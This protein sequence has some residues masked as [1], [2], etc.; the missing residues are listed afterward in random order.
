MASKEAEFNERVKEPPFAVREYAAHI[1]AQTIVKTDFGKA[2]RQAFGRLFKY[3]SGH[4]RS[5][6]S[7]SGA[8]DQGQGQGQKIA[9]TSPVIQNK[10]NEK[11]AMTSPVH[12]RQ[13]N[14]QWQVSF[15]MPAGSR[16]AELPTPQDAS[17][18]LAAV[19][20]QCM[21]VIRYSGSWSEARFQAHK[22]RLEH[23]I[24]AKGYQAI[25]AAS[26]ARYNPPFTL[27]FLRRNEILI[28]ISLP[29]EDS[30]DR[31]PS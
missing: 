14:E 22:Q 25:G 11:I 28:P 24:Q 21:A 30:Q 1:E 10:N 20:A 13:I 9:M 27:W 15:I 8:N 4:N 17:V 6:L 26:W 16:L 3:I 5:A 29:T 2:G 23:W 18:H 12:Q 7:Q 31:A 19:P